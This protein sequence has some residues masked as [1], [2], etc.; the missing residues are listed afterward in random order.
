MKQFIIRMCQI[1]CLLALLLGTGLGVVLLTRQ[2]SAISPIKTDPTTTRDTIET[3]QSDV[4]MDAMSDDIQQ[5]IDQSSLEIGVSV[6]DL[7]TNQQ[8][9]VGESAAFLGASTT[10]VLTAA[11]FM[12]QVEQG[13]ASLSA[14]INGSTA[15]SLMQRML[16][17]SDNTA[18][19][20]LNDYLG[21]S[22]LQTY[23]KQQGLASYNSTA[24]TIT[25]SDQAK[26]MAALQSNRLVSRTHTATI[27]YYMQQ[28]NNETLIPAALPADAAIYHK[29]GQLYGELHDSAIVTYGDIS[30]VLVIFTKSDTDTIPD[31]VSRTELFHNITDA[32]LRAL[33][34]N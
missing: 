13:K 30:F 10:K 31:L 34:Q 1:L 28:T 9:N 33:T 21:K 23:A 7:N 8:I 5:I 3:L 22:N 18:W 24:N 11:Y 25:T 14:I 4:D 15:Q 20:A 27:L 16:N 2:T 12:H 26:L 17:K 6:I 19:V 29:Y 32:T